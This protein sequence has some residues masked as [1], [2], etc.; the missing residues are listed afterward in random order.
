MHLEVAARAGSRVAAQELQGPPCP[1]AL[2][3]VWGWFK[4]LHAARGSSG[5]GLNP[6]GWAELDAFGRVNTLGLTPIETEL[7]LA[8]D[9][10]ALEQSAAKKGAA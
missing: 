4:A 10:V 9:R 1:N 8:L 3:H 2:E 6:I 7:L 5:F